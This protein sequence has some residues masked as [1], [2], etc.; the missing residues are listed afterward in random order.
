MCNIR[1]ISYVNEFITKFEAICVKFCNIVNPSQKNR[2]K[3]KFN[4]LLKFLLII[5]YHVKIYAITCTVK[6]KKVSNKMLY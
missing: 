4:T 6:K 3:K 2:E 5:T 1:N